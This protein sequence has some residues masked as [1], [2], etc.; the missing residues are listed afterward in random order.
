MSSSGVQSLHRFCSW[1]QSC[2]PSPIE[3]GCMP[4]QC[5]HGPFVG[6]AVSRERSCCA[7]EDRFSHLYMYLLLIQTC[8]P[9]PNVR[10]CGPCSRPRCPG[11]SATSHHIVSRY[12]RG[13]TA[14]HISYS[15]N[16]VTC[17]RPISIDCMRAR[18]ML[19]RDTHDSTAT[20]HFRACRNN[21]QSSML[22]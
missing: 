19:S 7:S 8:W 4:L 1:P 14:Q 12:V 11:L 6:E 2:R 20:R 10:V 9:W 5:T 18:T 22:R 15:E 21:L 13:C 16:A 3:C 17:S